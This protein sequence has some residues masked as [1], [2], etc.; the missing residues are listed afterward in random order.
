MSIQDV[1]PK[2]RLTLRYRTEIYGEP[3]DIVLP[4]R[5]LVIGDFTGKDTE[6]PEFEER[7]IFT[8]E[9]ANI[10]PLMEYM[11]IKLKVKDGD[12]NEHKIGIESIDSF[13]PTELINDIPDLKRL[14]HGEKVLT[15]V[16]SSLDNSKKFRKIMVNLIKKEGEVDAIKSRLEAAYKESVE[17]VNLLPENGEVK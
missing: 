10:R 17:F 16:L 13:L 6:K 14:L 2:S 12:D 4:L 8:T 15:H 3:E 7:P 11:D 9:R 5:L 1:L